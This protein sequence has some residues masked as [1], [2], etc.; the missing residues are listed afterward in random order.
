MGFVSWLSDLLSKVKKAMD[1]PDFDVQTLNLENGKTQARRSSS[2]RKASIGKS[3][4]K[5]NGD[6]LRQSKN[7]LAEE[8]EAKKRV[9]RSHRERREQEGKESRRSNN[10]ENF[11]RNEKINQLKCKEKSVNV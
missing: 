2:R 4:R 9:E 1:S 10:N 8:R 3:D 5:R 7:G 11:P 6:E